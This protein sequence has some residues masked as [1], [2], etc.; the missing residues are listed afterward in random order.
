[1]KIHS[2]IL[3]GHP[4]S[5]NIFMALIKNR[6]LFRLTMIVAV[7]LG[8]VS[9]SIS[10]GGSSQVASALH[11]AT[12]IIFLVLTVLQAFQT[13]LL[14]RMEYAGTKAVAIII[15]NPSFIPRDSFSSQMTECSSAMTP[16]R[17]PLAKD[18]EVLS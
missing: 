10:N 3:S 4:K 6:R 9:S 15:D 8:S 1:M 12:I 18:T 16:A 2:E 5:K 7:V 14:I 11:K 17:E 13:V